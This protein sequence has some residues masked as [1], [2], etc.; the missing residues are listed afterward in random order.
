MDNDD[1]KKQTLQRLD[2]DDRYQ[3]VLASVDDETKKKID[4][5]VRSFIGELAD[6][7]SKFQE[8]E[9]AKKLIELRKKNGR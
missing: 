4:A 1:L 3:R 8:P 7:L 6:G 2:V 9:I 5:I